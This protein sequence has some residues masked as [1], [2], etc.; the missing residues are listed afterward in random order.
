MK[1]KITISAALVAVFCVAEPPAHGGPPPSPPLRGAPIGGEPIK[2]ALAPPVTN[3]STNPPGQ[4]AVPATNAAV[5]QKDGDSA[6]D[7]K[8]VAAGFDKLAGFNLETG[9]DSPISEENRP[10]A[11]EKIMK[12]VPP[13]VKVLNE[14]SV[15]VRGFMLP[16]R[17]DHGMVTEFILLRNQMGC[18]YGMAPG[19]SE[20]IDVHT[21]GKGVKPQI[22]DLITVCGTL[23]IGAVFENS[24]LTGMYKMDCE[25]VKEAK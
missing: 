17:M 21:S 18:C 1:S 10:A 23:H 4:N 22:D 20:W 24:Y 6:K 25:D 16:M 8:F 19:I 12:Q 9:A 14:K 13:A 7:S 11:N 3:S 5:A 15:A 2:E